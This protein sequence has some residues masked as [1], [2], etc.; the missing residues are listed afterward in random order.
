[1]GSRDTSRD[2]SAST[3]PTRPLSTSATSTCSTGETPVSSFGHPYTTGSPTTRRNRWKANRRRAQGEVRDRD[4]NSGSVGAGRTETVAIEDAGA[5]GTERF[6]RVAGGL[7][8]PGSCASCPTLSVDPAHLGR[9][10][11][12]SLTYA[13]RRRDECCRDGQGHPSAPPDVRIRARS[14]RRSLRRVRSPGKQLLAASAL[15]RDASAVRNRRQAVPAL[16]TL[17]LGLG[18]ALVPSVKQLLRPPGGE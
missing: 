2:M 9:A 13:R 11:S 17:E 16:R 1:M 12:W 15:S 18:L 6:G 10:G 7:F 8:R 3:R 4:R 5:V 14:E